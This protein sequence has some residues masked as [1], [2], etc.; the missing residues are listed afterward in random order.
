MVKGSVR[1]HPVFAQRLSD[2]LKY[3]S[4]CKSLKF[5]APPTTFYKKYGRKIKIKIKKQSKKSIETQ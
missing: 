3:S 5:P 4:G 1:T 2:W